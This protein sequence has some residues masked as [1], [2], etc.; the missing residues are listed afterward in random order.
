MQADY[1]CVYG[2]L[3]GKYFVSSVKDGVDIRSHFLFHFKEWAGQKIF[4]QKS[5]STEEGKGENGSVNNK[6]DT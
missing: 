1:Q 2:T 3:F 6:K 5:I 4:K